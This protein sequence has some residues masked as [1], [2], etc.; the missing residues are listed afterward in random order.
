MKKMN[1]PAQ[2][3]LLGI[4]LMC[5]SVVVMCRAS[6]TNFAPP[7]Q[8]G[9]NSDILDR[10]LIFTEPDADNLA[11][12]HGSPL[13]PKLSLYVGGNY[14]FAMAPLVAEFEHEH[15]EYLG[16][17]YWETL[18]PGL[19]I[20]QIRNGG[21]ITV[22]NMTLTV[23]ADVYLAGIGRVQSGVT[24]KWLDAPVVC[25]ATNT[26]TMMIAK[27]NPKHIMSLMDLSRADV[28]LAMPNPAYE[29]I[30]RQIKQS[31]IQAGGEK[32]DQAV[33]DLKVGQGSTLLTHIHHRQTPLWI[34][35]G[36]VDAGVTWL[37]EAI[38]QESVG[39][40][41]GHVAIPNQFNVHAVYAGALVHGALHRE[42]GKL[43]LQFMN[44]KQAQ[45]ILHRYG[46]ATY[47][48]EKE[49]SGH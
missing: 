48:A 34:M 11:D 41:I 10:G 47:A 28:R 16:K 43:W 18:P 13:Q 8:H 17:L 6:D 2:S 42:A 7:W 21:T 31:L 1:L 36:K 20:R 24:E 25:Y 33:Y 35:Q 40:P 19:L 32:L 22:G 3:F 44:S 46:F 12:L 26:L 30:A 38:F 23:P 49:V 15:P 4:G 45:S 14:F 39:H 27:G 5:L 37:S 29:G 9:A